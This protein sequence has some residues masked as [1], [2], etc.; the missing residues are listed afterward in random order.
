[1]IATPNG[2]SGLGASAAP[3]RPILVLEAVRARD[4]DETSP[5]GRARGALMDVSLALG[6]GVHAVL[7]GPEDGTIALHGVVTGARPRLRGALHVRGQDPHRDPRIRARIGALGPE[8]LLPPAATVGAAVRLA[9]LSRGDDA[10]GVGAVL[11][12]LGLARLHARSLP[13]LSFG[14]ARAVT[15]A[16]ALSTKAPALIALHEPLADVV[17]PDPSLIERRA[18]EIAAAGACVLVTTSSPHDARAVAERLFVLH[19]GAVL[20]EATAGSDG[21]G[22]PSFAEL[23]AWVGA[24]PHGSATAGARELAAALARAPEARAVTWEAEPSGLP[25]PSPAAAVV[26]L[27]ADTIEACSAALIDAAVAT[28]V[29]VVALTRSS[30][31]LREVHAA[32]DALLRL[33]WNERRPTAPFQP[34]ATV[35][36]VYSTPRSRSSLPIPS[37]PSPAEDGGPLGRPKS[38]PAPPRSDQGLAGEAAAA[39][40]VLPGPPS[41]PNVA[42]PEAPGDAEGDGGAAG[43][44]GASRGDAFEGRGEASWGDDFEGRGEALRD[45][46]VDGR[47]EASWDDDFDGRG[48]R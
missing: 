43:R 8:A 42:M 38:F 7:G 37:S 19:R 18:R 34:P 2:A 48:E 41:L 28:G 35:L 27:R 1:L 6:P 33:R 15:L 10:R 39:M 4:D 30:P 24:G 23:S 12:I 11:D 31:D 26:R 21:L 47:G 36:A 29:V 44:L 9:L 20:R 16:L 25:A 46:D 14:E 17:V 40:L 3:P 32:T 5:K 22:A 13:S 45:D